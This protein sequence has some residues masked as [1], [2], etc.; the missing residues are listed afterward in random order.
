[1]R[2]IIV[3]DIPESCLECKASEKIWRGNELYIDCPYLQYTVK[4]PSKCDENC[5]IK[6]MPGKMDTD[7]CSAQSRYIATGYNACIDEILKGAE[8]GQEQTT[9]R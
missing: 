9:D 6:K 8:N 5:P 7:V 4:S 3:V 1:M 2:G